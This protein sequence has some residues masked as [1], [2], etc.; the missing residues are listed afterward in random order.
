[1]RE[2]LSIHPDHGA[3]ANPKSL[4]GSGRSAIL[5][6][7]A[8]GY[9]SAGRASEWHVDAAERCGHPLSTHV[10]GERNR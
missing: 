4:V 10:R 7:P 1:M 6:A 2:V 8:W 3:S 5:R 9:S